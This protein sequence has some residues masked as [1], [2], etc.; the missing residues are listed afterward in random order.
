MPFTFEGR[1]AVQVV[2]RDISARKRAERLQRALYR[3]AE[4]S[5]SVQD[6]PGFYASIHRIVGELMYARNFY[7]ALQDEAGHGA[8]L[9]VLRGRGGP[10]AAPEI[11]E[12]KTLTE[13]V[14]RT[15][16]PLLASPAV[17][18]RLV[19]AGEVE[20]VGAPSVDWL[21]VPLMRGD[22]AFGVLV[23]QSY[24]ESARYTEEDRDILTF[25]SQHVAAAL[26]RRRAA[27]A[28]RESE[29]RFRTLAE[30]APCAIFIY[31]DEGFR[32]ANPAAASIT[33]YNREEL[34][35]LSF[36]GLVHP[37][38]REAVQGARP[39][40]A[41]RGRRSPR[42]TSSRS[43]AGTA[44]SAG[45]TPP[46]APSSSGAGRPCSASP[47]TSPSASAPRSR[48][49]ASPTTT[50]LTGLPNRL[51]FND[52]LNVA[53]AQAH[54][55]QQRL[56]VLFLDLDRFKVINDSLGHSLGD[57]LLQAVAER[58]RGVRA[59]G[60]HGGPPRRRRVHPP[61]ARHRARPTTSPRS[62]RRSW[63]RC[64]CPSASRGASCSSPPASA[65]ASIPRTAS[66]RRRWSRTP[67]SRCTGPRSRAA[68]TTSSTP[69]P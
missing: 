23:V 21:G 55:Q 31:Q 25:V 9:P 43:S 42:A 60:R 13:Y 67:T 48:S 1:P 49:R 29:A 56:A 34:R 30:T 10:G 51:L 54:R 66:T 19:A 2:M 41:G 16:A 59:R 47:S 33:G 11:K 69:R 44:R 4:I 52:R 53:V 3:I 50:S 17:F 27:D 61:A 38:F 26:D 24:S 46:P 6:M 7:L 63:S 28:L 18:E 32:Y 45:W 39:D 8:D 57:R 36:W 68:T 15:G 35:D 22:S 64:A 65:S 37:D 5:S 62:R 40:P 58:L 14:L 20:V 12:G